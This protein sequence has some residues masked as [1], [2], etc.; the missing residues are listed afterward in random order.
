MGGHSRSLNG[1]DY[2]SNNTAGSRK[3]LQLVE[4]PG[5]SHA[6]G[7]EL[8]TVLSVAGMTCASCVNGIEQHISGVG[9]VGSIK[10]DLMTAQAIVRHREPAA[11]V[12]VVRTAIEAMGYEV[13]VLTS[14]PVGSEAA[15]AGDGG[16]AES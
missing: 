1:S 10:V 13:E 6:A 14:K 5:R 12:K 16:I 11:S 15:P 9:G 2:S 3:S 7:T 4:D 8:E